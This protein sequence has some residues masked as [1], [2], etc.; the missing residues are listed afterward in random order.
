MRWNP[1]LIIDRSR[2]FVGAHPCPLE[3]GFNFSAF[4][5]LQG[6]GVGDC[7]SYVGDTRLEAECTSGDGL[8]FRFRRRRCVPPE[9]DA[10]VT[11]RMYCVAEWSSPLDDGQKYVVLRHDSL[12]RAW[13]LRYPTHHHSTSAGSFYAYL[14]LDLRCV[15]GRS[16]PTA[17]KRYL[18]LEMSRDSR[19]DEQQ[20]LCVDD[21]EA[22]SYWASPTCP[23]TVRNNRKYSVFR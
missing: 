2:F 16:T 4:D 7:D 11:Q 23:K 6:V 20:S 1:W 10:A 5:A 9:L 18:R 21:Y 12:E 8:V 22:C 3:G 19:E 17:T 13:C 15:V 14:F